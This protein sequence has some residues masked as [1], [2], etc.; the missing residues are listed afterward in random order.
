MTQQLDLFGDFSSSSPTSQPSIEGFGKTDRYIFKNENIY[1]VYITGPISK[2]GNYLE[3]FDLLKNATANEKI[4]IFLSTPG[5]RLDTTVQILAL[6]EI[7]EAETICHVMSYI[8]S[9]GT[10]IA[11]AADNLSVSPFGYMMLHNASGGSGYDKIN[12]SK[13]LMDNSVLWCENINR[14]VYANFLTEEEIDQLLVN[15][16]FHFNQAEILERWERVLE[17]RERA[18]E[19]FEQAEREAQQA[20]ID[21]ALAPTVEKIKTELTEEILEKVKAELAKQVTETVA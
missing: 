7:T 20:A 9:A 15:K 17:A 8:A 14:S 3:F 12:L 11:L 1:D 2:P 16:D 6:M 4:N 18:T 19:E 10:L 5:G 21:A 13:Q